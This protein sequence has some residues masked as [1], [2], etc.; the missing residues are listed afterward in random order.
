MLAGVA[1]DGAILVF[2]ARDWDNQTDT[3][4]AAYDPDTLRRI[5]A[6]DVQLPGQAIAAWVDGEHVMWI[7]GEHR[8][9]ADG[10]RI[11]GRYRWVRSA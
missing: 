6:S 7:D 3:R 4:L 1:P 10:E 11:T 2:R 9:Y 8:M 5:P